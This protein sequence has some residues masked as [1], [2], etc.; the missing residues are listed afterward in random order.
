MKKFILFFL[1]LTNVS[2]FAQLPG[3]TLTG[4]AEGA[5]GAKW[6]YNNTV[7]GVVYDLQGILYKP[8][9]NGPF[10][11][12]IINHGTGGSSLTYSSNSAKQM[13]T[14]GYVCIAT[15][16]THAAISASVPCGLPG[17]CADQTT[18]G[19]SNDNF[20][21]AMKCWDILASLAYADTNSIAAFGHSRGAFL[22]IGLAGTYPNKFSCFGHTAGGVGN[23]SDLTYAI[24]AEVNNIN[25]PYIF[26]HGDADVTVPII[27]DNN[28][29]TIFIKNGVLYNYY[30]Y[31]GLTHS[32]MGTDATMYARTKD[33]FNLHIKRIK[34]GLNTYESPD[35]K[36]IQLDIVSHQLKIE[37][38]DVTDLQIYN[39]TGQQMFSTNIIP[40]QEIDI[41]SIRNGLYICKIS[42]GSNVFS[43]KIIVQ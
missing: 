13:V 31:P 26:H 34:T 37:N 22:T 39:L 19:A 12:V 7:N 14:W 30:I 24:E 5:S 16:Y 23:T 28:I 25:K 6:T 17:D 43:R 38:E 29:E 33:F 40:N 2:V 27:Y 32:Q 1:L 35:Q 10:P 20:L 18:W 8:I 36:A 4:N 3:F 9:G 41:S 11:A 15:N 21:R 42:L